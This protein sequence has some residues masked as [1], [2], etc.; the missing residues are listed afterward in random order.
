MRLH[1]IIWDLDDDP[2]GN[3]QHIGE[4]GLEIEEIEEV[5]EA[6]EEVIA[7]DSSGRPLVFGHT[8]TGKYIAVAFD[9]VD[10]DPPVV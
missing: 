3:V 4:H 8:S 7:S 1:Q 10:E 9:I 2:D 5:L 6:A